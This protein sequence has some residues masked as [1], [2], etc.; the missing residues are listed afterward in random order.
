MVRGAVNLVGVV[1]GGAGVGLDNADA[2]SR[3]GATHCR[4]E[5]INYF[6]LWREGEADR[7]CCELW[8][9]FSDVSDKL[10]GS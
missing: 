3:Y 1:G 8:R 4:V 5:Y 2:V 7:V 10:A 9:L 6:R